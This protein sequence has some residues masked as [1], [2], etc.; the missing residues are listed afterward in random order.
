MRKAVFLD[1]DGTINTEANY[2]YKPEDFI[3]TPGAI[4]AI[5]IFHELGYLVI[6]ITNQAGVARGYYTEVD[7]IKLHGYVD[8][9][10]KAEDTYIDAYFYCPHHPEGTLE[11][12][13]GVCKCRK[14]ES[15]MIE[16]AARQFDLDL[17][18]CIIAG[19]NEID[20]KTGKNAGIGENGS[21]KCILV[22]SG[23]PIDEKNSEADEIYDNLYAFA[24]KM[25]SSR[26]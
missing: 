20:V 26:G 12:Y 24:Q 6:V 4:D 22:R 7:V 5:K 9:L 23:H 11:G 15:G 10:L 16:Q 14:P 25:I 17:S 13:T 8:E 3:F 18:E 2:L 19:D 21:G 1:R